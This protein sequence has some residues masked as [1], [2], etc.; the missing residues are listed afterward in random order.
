M[1]VYVESL[2]ERTRLTQFTG[3]KASNNLWDIL[4]N[5]KN[6]QTETVILKSTYNKQ[7]SVVHK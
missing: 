2:L 6:N 5:N 4:G 3:N 7:L 1:Q